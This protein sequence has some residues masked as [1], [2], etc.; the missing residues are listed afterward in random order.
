MNRCPC[1]CRHCVAPAVVE[2]RPAPE[3]IPLPAV[4]TLIRVHHDGRTQDCTLY[5]DGTLTALLGG[6]LRRNFFTLAEMQERNWADAYIEFD[7]QPL[8]AEP[9]PEAAPVAEQ[10]TFAA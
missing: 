4:P 10:I 3:P 2:E 7:P 9:E 6:E 8:E 1:T 5:P